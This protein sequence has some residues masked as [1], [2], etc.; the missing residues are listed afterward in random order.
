MMMNYYSLERSM[1][2]A[3]ERGQV[4]QDFEQSDYANGKYFSFYGTRYHTTF[5]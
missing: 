3:K 4:Y 5:R 2:I 1:Q